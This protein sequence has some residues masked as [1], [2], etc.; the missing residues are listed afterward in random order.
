[1][2]L[3]ANE[4][5]YTELILPQTFR[6]TIRRCRE[7]QVNPNRVSRCGPPRHKVIPRGL[8]DALR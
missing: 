8:R 2:V 7:R 6:F 1:M 4:H 5:G 3:L